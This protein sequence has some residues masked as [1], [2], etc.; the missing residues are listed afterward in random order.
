M[1][2]LRRR[3]PFRAGIE[4]GEASLNSFA[5]LLFSSFSG[6]ICKKI[7]GALAAIA[8]NH[9]F[10]NI[11]GARL[12]G[13]LQF[14]LSLAYVVGSVAL[15]FGSPVIQ[16][17]L[18]KHPRLRAHR[19]LPDIPP[20]PDPDPVRDGAFHGCRCARDGLVE[21]IRADADRGARTHRR[22]DR[23]GFADGLCRNQAVGH[24]ARQ[25]LCKRCSRTLALLPPRTHRWGP[26]LPRS[27]GRSKRAWPRSRRSAGIARL[28]CIHPN[29]SL[30]MQS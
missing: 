10:A 5:Q 16:P 20:A 18:G 11:Y 25:G 8:S 1:V 22:T 3:T 15:I 4:A 12:F 19:L 23:A 26:S 7:V 2:A 27:R 24:Y 30:A 28:P 9:L 29:R 13:E 17:I 21:R 6:V 14:A